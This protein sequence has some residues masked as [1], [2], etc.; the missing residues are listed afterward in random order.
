MLVPWA[1]AAPGVKVQVLAVAP[2]PPPLMC[3]S[4]TITR[5]QGTS[6]APQGCQ[7]VPASVLRTHSSLRPRAFTWLSPWQPP[8][9]HSVVSSSGDLPRQSFQFGDCSP[10]PRPSLVYF[11]PK[12]FTYGTCPVR[13][14]HLRA[15]RGH[16]AL[17]LLPRCCL[18]SQSS[19]WLTTFLKGCSGGNAVWRGLVRPI[20]CSSHSWDG[21]FPPPAQA[22]PCTPLEAGIGPGRVSQPR[23]CKEEALR[24][25]GIA[26]LIWEL[27]A[28]RS[29]F[30]LL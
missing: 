19:A 21:T 6:A 25:S 17:P 16:G 12:R 10:S 7:P 1:A 27:P 28:T 20:P 3:F 2:I 9:L 4:A 23:S 5:G 18:G 15:C 30:L 8:P 24:F 11:A 14:T 29:H 26:E 22:A 13:F